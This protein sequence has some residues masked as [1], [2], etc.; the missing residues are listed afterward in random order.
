M[1]PVAADPS[2]PTSATRVFVVEDE[3]LIAMELRDRLTDLGYVVCGSASRGE[4]ALELISTSA[5]DLVLM[6]VRLAGSLS[7]V[8]TAKRLRH[9]L[10]VP[11]IFL[12]AYSDA[13]VLREASEVQPFGYLVKPFDE[14]ELHATIQ[15][16]LYKYRMDR[17][18]RESHARLEEK[19][20]QRTAALAQSRESLA[21]TL[22]SIGEAVLTTDANG[23]IT[24]MNPAAVDLTDWSQNEAVGQPA[25]EVLRFINAHTR[26]PVVLPMRIVLATGQRQFLPKDTILIA[27][28]GG[29]RS[30]SDSA[31]PIR[32]AAGRIVG[33]VLVL[34]DETEAR[35]TDLQRREAEDCFR[36]L[37]TSLEMFETL[38][39]L[40]PVGIVRTDAAAQCE[41]VNER[42]CE[43]LGIRRDEALGSSWLR[44]TLHEEDRDRVMKEW[45][46]A[47]QLEQAFHCNCRFVRPDGRIVFALAQSVPIRDAQGTITGY[48]GTLTDVTGQQQSSKTA[49][50]G[51]K[52][53]SG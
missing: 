36:R 30:I 48:I 12:S 18:L 47:V 24:L 45:D 2:M 32:D 22:D 17:A 29:E 50:S 44:T 49:Q 53:A 35:W 11:V 39:A 41:Y 51:Q 25:S 1:N 20:R 3:A 8:D 10:D 13:E 43:M 42:Y 16:A 37:K 33:M 14:R 6:D 23:V 28:N 7:G 9:Q 38:A 46:R 26:E 21:V 4:Q 52:S 34:R 5:P 19:V 27:R 15:V 31:A 40:S